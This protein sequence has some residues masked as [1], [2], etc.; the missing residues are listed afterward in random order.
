MDRLI[1]K[2]IQRTRIFFHLLILFLLIRIFLGFFLQCRLVVDSGDEVETLDG[3]G[4]S[5]LPQQVSG[6]VSEEDEQSPSSKAKS[7]H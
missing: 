3:L 4:G 2:E 7:M 1:S 6:S 5:A